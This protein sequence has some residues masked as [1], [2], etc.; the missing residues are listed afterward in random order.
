MSEDALQR[1]L[2]ELHG[3]LGKA[4]VREAETRALL[5]ELARDIDR[6]LASGERRGLVDRLRSVATQFEG[7]HPDLAVLTTRVID[8]LV[9]LGF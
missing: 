9:K 3:A 6:A 5:H 4:D 7:E 8:A 2:R 1:Q